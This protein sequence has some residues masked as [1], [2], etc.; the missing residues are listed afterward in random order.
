LVPVVAV[1]E[2]GWRKADLWLAASM[3]FVLLFRVPLI[4]VVSSL[5]LATIVGLVGLARRAPLAITASI[6]L[7]AGLSIYVIPRSFSAILISRISQLHEL[8]VDHRRKPDGLEINRDGIRF[9]GGAEDLLEEEYVVLFL[10]DSFTFGW[11]LPYEQSYPYT[12][13]T[14]VADEFRCS[15]SVRAVNL[16]WTS[17]SPLLSLRLL[18][19]IGY[20]YRPDLVLYNL[21]MTDFHDDLRY[22]IAL[23]KG[24]DFELDGSEVT[25]RLLRLWLPGVVFD[26]ADFG[27][28]GELLRREE[29]EAAE[30]EDGE[31]QL[32]ESR[33][34]VTELPLEETRSH[35]E[36]GVKK[37]LDGLH[38]YSRDV[39]A[40]AMALVLYPRAYQYSL[41]ESPDNWEASEYEVLGPFV[42]EPLRYFEKRRPDLPYPVVSLWSA[43]TEAEEFPLF[44]QND[45]HW[46]REGAQVA[47]RSLARQLS[48]RGLLPCEE[49]SGA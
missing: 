32:P 39:L 21:D 47:A 7:A 35:I 6:A 9:L 37:N 11:G 3:I 1:V 16:G 29:V 45:P 33:F 25:H 24:A 8:T 17:S 12:F 44:R 10:G 49:P 42:R 40:A 2:Q 4:L 19:E 23:R 41:R 36:R 5:L 34:F 14:I 46:T 43:F 20:K 28:L 13:E 15:S 31:I 27:A 26:L 18:R 48:Q 30:Q 22:E 38:A